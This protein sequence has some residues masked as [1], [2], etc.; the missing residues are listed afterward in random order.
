MLLGFALLTPWH[1]SAWA[2]WPEWITYGRWVIAIVLGLFAL[3]LLSKGLLD[4][5][6][7]LTPLP[8]P[9]DDSTLVQTGVYGWVRHCLYSGLIIGTLAYSLAR[10]SV[11]HLLATVLLFLILDAKSRQEEVWLMAKFPDYADY[12]QR[13]KKFFP[14]IY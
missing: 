8:Y 12:R 4:L 2:H 5:G 6:Q 10:L 3:F 11:P 7:N 1:P 14:G 9:R 13:V